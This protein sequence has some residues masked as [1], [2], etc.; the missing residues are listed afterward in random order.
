MGYF[1]KL[2]AQ[3][4]VVVAALLSI[5]TAAPS[6]TPLTPPSYPLAVRTPYLSG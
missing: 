4:A 3:W 5:T 1:A 6:F 2:T